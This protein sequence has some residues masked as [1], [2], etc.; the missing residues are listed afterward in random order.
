MCVAL[1]AALPLHAQSFDECTSIDVTDYEA[2][3]DVC[4]ELLET[5]PLNIDAYFNRAY[6][7]T[8]LGNFEESIVDYTKV[9]L[10]SPKYTFAYNNRGYAYARLGDFEAAVA[11]YSRAIATDSSYALAIL[12]RAYTYIDLGDYDS[13]LADADMLAEIDPLNI[14]VHD[15][16]GSV[17]LDQEAYED[18]IDAY[19]TYIELA[20]EDPNGYL[21]RGFAYWLLD[22]DERA[23]PDYLFWVEANSP[24]VARIDPDDA[25]EPFTVTMEEG[26]RYVLPIEAVGGDV[27]TASAVSE[28]ETIDP[29]LILLDGNGDPITMDDDGAGGIAEVDAIIED[30]E[31]P[32]DGDYVLVIGYAGG[33]SEGDVRLDVRLNSVR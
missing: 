31:I 17:Y 29:V 14:Y 33:G 18:A 10:L 16:R 13:A 26:I 32:E 20:P 8:E 5:D 24:R 2:V 6:A 12:N 15:I 28:V 22:D 30:F 4:T 7:Q 1:V 3:V 25:L 9:L 23:A 21:A 11:D 19:T 27:L